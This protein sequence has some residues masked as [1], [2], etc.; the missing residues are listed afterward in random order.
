MSK[1][2]G[3]VLRGW[4]V[5]LGAVR[6]R[7]RADRGRGGPSIS[8]R[9]GGENRNR[10]GPFGAGPCAGPSISGAVILGGPCAGL[11]AVDLG[12]G[13]FRCG[14]SGAARSVRRMSRG[15]PCA[16]PSISGPCAGRPVRRNPKTGIG[17][18]A[19][20]SARGA[21]GWIAARPNRESESVRGLAGAVRCGGWA[22]RRWQ[23]RL[24]GVPFVAFVYLL[25]CVI[26]RQLPW[27][28]ETIFLRRSE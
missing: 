27:M 26:E 9:S 7:L 17:I 6:G 3:A 15:G 8:G 2:R 25:L 10:C 19:A 28:M 5:D 1:A 20:R 21:G 11:G 18:G 16:G 4:P 12:A 14:P 23:C 13:G 22:A 24:Y